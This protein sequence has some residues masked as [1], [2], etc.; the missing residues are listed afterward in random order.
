MGKSVTGALADSTHERRPGLC[1]SVIVYII[2]DEEFEDHRQVLE[3]N[4]TRRKSQPVFSFSL[5]HHLK[6][7][8]LSIQRN[9][10]ENEMPQATALPIHRRQYHAPFHSR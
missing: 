7:C 8:D 10:R 3:T 1:V 2:G 9:C 5:I 6:F 4:T